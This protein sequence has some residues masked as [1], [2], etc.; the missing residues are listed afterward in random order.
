PDR[1]SPTSPHPEH[2]PRRRDS[3]RIRVGA[4]AGSARGRARLRVAWRSAM[5][6]SDDSRPLQRSPRFDAHL[7]ARV[8]CTEWAQVERL[9]TLNV[10]RGGVFLR[11]ARI[12]AIGSPLRLDLELPNGMKL[13]LGCT[14]VHTL[15][16]DQAAAA[17]GAPGFGVQFDPGHESD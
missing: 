12:P 4:C 10:S 16:P 1:G 17:G 5:A 9:V 8:S 6:S 3:K 2:A 11:S 15:S 13:Q 7:P 14:V